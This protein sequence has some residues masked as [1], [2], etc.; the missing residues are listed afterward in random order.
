M[1]YSA[2]LDQ[3]T[4]APHCSTNRNSASKFS[5]MFGVMFA[6]MLAFV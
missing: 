2:C 5:P 3:Y 4:D 1:T 6:I